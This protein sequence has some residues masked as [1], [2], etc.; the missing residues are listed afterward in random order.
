MTLKERFTG[1]IVTVVI[2]RP[3]KRLGFT[4]L[5]QNL[6]DSGE[7]LHRDLERIEGTDKNLEQLRHII[8]IERWGQRRLKVALGEPFLQDENHAYKPA[9]DTS[10]NILKEMFTATRAET[11][12]LTES[13]KTTDITL[14]VPHNQF[15]LLSVLGWLRYLETHAKLEG[16]RLR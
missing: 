10:W 1:I 8:A 5:T 12:T 3:A 11:L 16:K 2:E 15:G 13:L 7:A 9:T 4:K 14:T 6:S